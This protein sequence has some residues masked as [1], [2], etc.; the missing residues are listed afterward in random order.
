MTDTKRNGGAVATQD[1]RAVT[2][3]RRVGELRD[4]FDR[5][6]T[7]IALALPKHLTPERMLRVALTACQKTPRLMDCD[8]KSVIGAVVQASQLGLE[9][10]GIL[11]GAYLVPYWNKKTGSYECQ[12]IPGYRGLMDLARRSGEISS[13]YAEP[14]YEHDRFSIEYGLKRDLQH[15]PADGE[16]GEFRGV[17]AVAVLRDGVGMQWVYMPKGEV[18]AIRSRSQSANNGPWVTDYVEMAKKTAIRRLCKTL[19]R[20]VEYRDH[21]AAATLERASRL[22]ETAERGLPQDIGGFLDQPEDQQGEP[23]PQVG[24]QVADEIANQQAAAIEEY[25]IAYGHCTALTE[26]NDL[27]LKAKGDNSLMSATLQEILHSGELRRDAIRA[28][29][30]DRAQA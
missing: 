7:Q 6:K 30:G 26:V 12:L 25:G 28:A 27:D 13:I 23:L 9:P 1:R 11:G 14:V 16:R 15:T 10:D 20:S 5:A 24:T 29:R 21:N 2:V 4:I 3:D 19:P 18:E 8:P 17:Y 22:D